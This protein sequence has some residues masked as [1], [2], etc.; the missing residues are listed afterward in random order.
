[1]CL[2]SG[3]RALRLAAVI[4]SLAL[5][6]VIK[7]CAANPDAADHPD[8]TDRFELLTPVTMMDGPDS[9]RGHDSEAAARGKYLVELLGCGSCHTQGAL[10]GE[11]DYGKRLAGSTTGISYSNPLTEEFPGVVYPA[12][13]TPDTETGIGSWSDEQVLEVIRSGADP[14]GRKHLPVMPWPAYA[15]ISDADGTAIVTYLRSL[16]P[17]KHAVPKNVLPGREAEYPYV[18][19]G[20]YRSRR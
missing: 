6:L 14:T 16:R 15:K 17:V 19:F 4:L 20:V 12:N 10:E 11:P 2:L 5:L 9:H 13:L 1:M 8:A 18:H 7:A 3:S